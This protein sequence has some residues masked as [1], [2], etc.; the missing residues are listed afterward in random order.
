MY[1]TIANIIEKIGETTLTQLTD[2]LGSGA[3]DEALVN[4]AITA[5][6]SIIDAYCQGP[7][8]P[9]HPMIPGLCVDLAVYDL[10]SRSDLALPD[11]RKDRYNN[12]ISFLN[13]VAAGTISLGVQEP[14]PAGS[15]DSAESSNS[16]PRIFD[17]DTMKG[18]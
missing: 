10:Y 4:A 1:C 8:S 2:D 17:R 5:A 11:I 13:K 3:I 15:K 6:G 12:A 18:F 14:A 7:L 16:G 9:V